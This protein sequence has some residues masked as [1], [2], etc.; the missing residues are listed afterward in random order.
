MSNL[1][2]RGEHVRR[3][4]WRPVR[5][6]GSARPGLAPVG[7]AGGGVGPMGMMGHGTKSGG[8]K[9]GLT[10][11]SPLAYDLGEDEEDDW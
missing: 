9:Q 1:I 6:R 8:S 2:G 3:C 5:P 7:A 4:R 11:P 10:A